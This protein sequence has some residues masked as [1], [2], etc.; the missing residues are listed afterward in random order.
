MR[1]RKRPVEVEA[2]HFD[3]TSAGVERAV[4][5]LGRKV[6]AVDMSATISGA[7]AYVICMETNHGEAFAQPGDWI[8]KGADFY[9]CKPEE[10]DRIYEAC[11]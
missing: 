1:F 3:G 9:S 2:I 11:D 7:M 4:A 5:F 8:I 10:F 6:K